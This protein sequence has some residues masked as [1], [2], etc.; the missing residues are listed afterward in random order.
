[1]LGTL[2]LQTLKTIRKMKKMMALMATLMITLTACADRQ[3]M[4][5]FSELPAEAQSFV[6]KYYNVSD[7][8]YVEKDWD[9]M[10]YEYTVYLKNATEIE[11]NHQGNMKSIDCKRS[12]VPTGIVPSTIVNYVKEHYPNDFIV[13]YVRDS[14][15]LQV[16]LNNGWELYFDLNGNFLRMD[17]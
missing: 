17:D 14:R 1:M 6:Q 11:F 12:A 4:I 13:E 8:S 7:I 5:Q 15:R 9:D 10:R 3:Q 16:E 2:K